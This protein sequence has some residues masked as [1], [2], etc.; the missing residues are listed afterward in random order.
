M[1][2][3]DAL[4]RLV[5]EPQSGDDESHTNLK[6][7]AR[8]LI[9][10]LVGSL[11]SVLLWTMVFHDGRFSLDLQKSLHAFGQTIVVA[12]S[13]FAVGVLFGFLFGI[14]KTLQDQAPAPAQAKPNREAAVQATNTNL[15]QISDWLT[16]ILVGVGLTQLNNLRNTFRD[17]ANYFAVA[18][19]PAVTLAMILN[20]SVAG[21]MTGYLLTRLFLTGAFV[22]VER[23]LRGIHE[24]TTR[25]EQLQEAGR[26]EAALSR[27]EDALHQVTP[28]TPPEER[29]RVYEGVIFNSLYEPPPDGFTRAIDYAKRYLRDEKAPPSA[30]ILAYLAGAY[31]QQYKYE[32]N[33]D[34]SPQRLV[35]IRMLALD[36]ARR[37]VSLEPGVIELLRVMWDPA[38]PSKSPDDDDLE[39]FFDDDDFRKLLGPNN[40]GRVVRPAR[41]T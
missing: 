40:E 25:A 11:F 5:P 3:L 37:A 36:A 20:F 2:L 32:R 9:L 21:F 24:S 23:T 33:Q 7:T 34:A 10:W 1:A 12:G 31:G 16:K 28:A 17:L 41:Q 26:F 4:K 6:L 29:R 15:E 8:V 27:F 14:P 30:K 35:E 19:A 38:H 39:V 13:A 18:G 22:S